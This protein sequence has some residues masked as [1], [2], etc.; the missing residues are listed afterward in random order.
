MPDTAWPLFGG[1]R[2]AV[3]LLSGHSWLPVFDHLVEVVEFGGNFA[4]RNGSQGL[5]IEILDFSSALTTPRG[6]DAGN[7]IVPLFIVFD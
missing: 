4:S 5:L 7:V 6:S 3:W 1:V 2:A